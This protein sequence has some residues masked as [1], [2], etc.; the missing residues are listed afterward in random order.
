[1]HGTVTRLLIRHV[2]I[3]RRQRSFRICH[4]YASIHSC[5]G[6]PALTRDSLPH[7]DRIP[8]LQTTSKYHLV[9]RPTICTYV[10]KLR[11]PRT[12]E[13]VARVVRT[14]NRS[15]ILPLQKLDKACVFS[16]SWLAPGAL[17]RSLRLY[18]TW[19]PTRGLRNPMS[20]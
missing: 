14:G 17:G 16:I 13:T 2:V 8:R 3:R 9:S 18:T 11:I 6:F 12:A 4:C 20:R 7:L 10:M 1:M 19:A 15:R 5:F